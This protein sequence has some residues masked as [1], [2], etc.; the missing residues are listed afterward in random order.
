MSMRAL[1]AGAVAVLALAV[2]GLAAATGQWI[3]G[4]AQVPERVLAAM[5]GLILLYL[6]PL[7]IAIGLGTLAVAL[8]VHV[9]GRRAAARTRVATP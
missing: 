1:M 9:V 6:E 8:V 5:G 3:I 7:T 2:A 4:P